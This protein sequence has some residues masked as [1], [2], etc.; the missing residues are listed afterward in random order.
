MLLTNFG[1]NVQS[2]IS[3]VTHRHVPDPTHPS[4]SCCHGIFYFDAKCQR[5]HWKNCHKARSNDVKI[6]RK[7]CL[8][9]FDEDD[10]SLIAKQQDDEA[11]IN[12][13]CFI[14]HSEPMT[15]PIELPKYGHA[16]RCS[17]LLNWHSAAHPNN[18]A[19]QKGAPDIVQ[20][21]IDAAFLYGTR[22][23][24]PYLTKDEQ[25]HYAGLALEQLTKF[26][27]CA[28]MDPNRKLQTLFTKAEMLQNHLDRPAES[29]KALEE[30]EG[31]KA[32]EW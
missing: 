10:I 19:C 16:F 17:C 18:P 29:L 11:A 3:S 14:C 5:A 23:N 20:S 22:S 12:T 15:N 21:I 31:S 25:K 13:C 32:A 24:N 26:D 2:T 28:T 8:G 9:E 6:S 27:Q 1:E 7:E 4:D 30:L